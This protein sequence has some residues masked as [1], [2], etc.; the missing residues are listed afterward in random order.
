MV[1]N[2]FKDLEKAKI[3]EA[4]VLNVLQHATDDYEFTDVSDKRECYYKGDIEVYDKWWNAHYFIDVK[5]D[6]CIGRTGNILCEEKVYFYDSGYRSGNMLSSYDYLAIISVDTQNIYIID[7]NKLKK[8]YRIGKR[9]SKDH[10]EQIT[11][12]YLFSLDKAWKLG[13]IEAVIKY[14]EREDGY[15]PI[16]VAV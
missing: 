9:Y 10:G 11:Y 16:N 13:M 7:F 15:Y 8:H 2:F 14:E 5:M 1:S 6:G 4:I 12:G 3:G